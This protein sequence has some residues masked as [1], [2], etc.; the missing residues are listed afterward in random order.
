[1]IHVLG[2]MHLQVLKRMEMP[3]ANISSL[4][5]QGDTLL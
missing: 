5:S 3:F 2:L 1:M 4:Q